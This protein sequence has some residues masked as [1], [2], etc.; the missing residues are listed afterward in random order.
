[1]RLIYKVHIVPIS[2]FPHLNSINYCTY[3]KNRLW[4]LLI[5]D[6]VQVNSFCIVNSTRGRILTQEIC[7]KFTHMDRKDPNVK[8]VTYSKNISFIRYQSIGTNYRRPCFFQIYTIFSNLK[9]KEFLLPPTSATNLLD[10][11]WRDSFSK[12]EV[13]K[14]T[15]NTHQFDMNKRAE[16]Y[17]QDIIR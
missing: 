1:M 17:R 7:S 9:K 3:F 12:W 2:A 13:L 6:Y 11:V 10:S 4:N 5:I 8:K 15:K 16:R 14:R